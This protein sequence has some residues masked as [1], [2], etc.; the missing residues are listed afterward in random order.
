MSIPATISASGSFST[1]SLIPLTHMSVAAVHDN[2][3]HSMFLL[4]LPL[5]VRL[6]SKLKTE[7]LD[8]F[9]KSCL[10]ICLPYPPAACSS[11]PTFIPTRFI[12]VLTGIGLTSLNRGID[13]RNSL[14]LIL[15]CTFITV[16]IFH[17]HIMCILRCNVGRY[18][19]YSKST[20]KESGESGHHFRV[21]LKLSVSQRHHLG[22]LG[23]ISCSFL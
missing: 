15:S 8:F 21:K 22:D 17:N 11:G 16:E 13:Q 12:A 19:D 23:K 18:G 20:E 5:T 1:M 10:C 4:Y 6:F 3:Y 14:Q 2:F 9:C 7:F